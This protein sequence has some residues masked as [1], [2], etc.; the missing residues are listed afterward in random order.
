[1]SDTYVECLVQARPSVPGKF[2]KVFL[3]ALTVILVIG[4]FIVPPLSLPLFVLAIASGVGAY[5]ANLF[6]D[7]EYEY[8]YLDK[9]IVID[10]VMAKSRRK[11]VA[12]YGLDKVEILAPV[13]SYRLDSY[14]RRNNTKVK[15][16]SIGEELQ[17]DR[18]Y[19][20]YCEGG[21]KILLS[22]SEEM[23]KVMKN[24]APRKVFSD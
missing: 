9:E 12:A 5:F 6:T 22:P 3:I 16:Y 10:K 7:L 18:R 8:L 15:D 11:R 24:A 20:M 14:S 4:M 23:I 2:L 1:M 17:P 21:E 13:K 19:V